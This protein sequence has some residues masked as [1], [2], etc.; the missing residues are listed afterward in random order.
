MYRNYPFRIILASASPRRKE[1]IEQLGFA[2]SIEVKP[3]DETPNPNHSPF[4]AVISIVKQKMDAFDL[5]CFPDNT[6]IITADTVVVL[7]DEILGKP[8]SHFEAKQ[9]LK[10]LSG[11]SHEVITAV[12]LKSATKSIIF[13]DKTT[14]FFSEIS[15]MEI[16]Y[17]I[18]NY[19]PFDKA[20]SYGI[21]EWIGLGFISSIKGS[22]TNV[23]GLPTEKLRKE[24]INFASGIA[25]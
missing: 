5:N 7:G 9:M 1:L 20:G 2:F 18:Q 14:V 15:D 21:Q 16:D 25:L 6:L 23:V 11:Q 19:Q 12:Y 22:Y 10:K 3:V 4:D 17:Y 13:H 8:N 24:L